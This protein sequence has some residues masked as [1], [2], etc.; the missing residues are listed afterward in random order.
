MNQYGTASVY[1]VD[2][3]IQYNGASAI[4]A[5]PESVEGEQ[6][7]QI[8]EFMSGIGELIGFKKADQREYLDLTIVPKRTAT[9]TGDIDAALG[10]LAYPTVPSKITFT[11]TLGVADSSTNT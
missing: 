4:A 6:R 9:G 3:T 10:A 1:S 5:F 8:E 11:P 7:V 2:G